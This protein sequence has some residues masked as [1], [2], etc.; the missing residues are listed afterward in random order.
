MV[1][2]KVTLK[3]DKAERAPGAVVL[4]VK[5]LCLTDERQV[6]LLD[7]L[8]F[9][10]RAGE[11]VGVA[12]VSGN[13]QSELLEVLAGMLS[14]SAGAVVYKGEDLLKLPCRRAPRAAV[15]RRKGISH[16]RRT[17]RARGW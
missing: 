6:K 7:G 11:I 5:N 1:G 13:G 10:V 14:P 17:V 3:V 12:G 4:D 9:Q 8:N 2:R 16:I 15:Y